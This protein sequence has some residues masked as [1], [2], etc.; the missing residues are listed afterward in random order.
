MNGSEKNKFFEQE[1]NFI[2]I[3]S[4]DKEKW[5]FLPFHIPRSFYVR[6]C[7]RFLRGARYEKGIKIAFEGDKGRKH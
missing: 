7:E 2:V 5:Q 6:A 1:I 3:F 4:H